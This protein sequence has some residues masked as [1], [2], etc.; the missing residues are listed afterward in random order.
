MSVK[1]NAGSGIAGRST[2]TGQFG[3]W[4]FNDNGVGIGCGTG[5]VNSAAFSP[6][7][8]NNDARKT[9]IDCRGGISATGKI[10]A[11]SIWT[12]ENAIT[13]TCTSDFSGVAGIN[14]GGGNGVYGSSVGGYAGYFSGPVHVTGY[15]SKPGGGFLVDHPVD[16]ANK[17]LYHSFIESPDMMNVYNGNVLLD[18]NGEASVRLPDYFEALNIDF[19]Y[20]LT[21]IGGYAPVYIADKIHDNAFRIAGGTGGLEISWQVTGIRNDPWANAHRIVS[22]VEKSPEERGKY[23]HAVEYGQPTSMA[24]R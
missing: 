20:Q 10:T 19:R 1:N 6:I 14:T 15:L 17:Y 24:I 16:P 4:G 7:A 21:C 11:N 9:A 12:G 22:E 18:E 2:T 13:G 3:I 8:Y 5:D 23:L